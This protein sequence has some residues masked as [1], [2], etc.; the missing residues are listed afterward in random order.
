LSFVMS[1]VKKPSEANF[2]PTHAWPR[3]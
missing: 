1:A 2:E 3:I